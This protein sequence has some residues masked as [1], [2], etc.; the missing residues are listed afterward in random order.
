MKRGNLLHLL[1]IVVVTLGVT[2][3]IWGAALA[4]DVTPIRVGSTLALTG[5]LAATGKIHQIAGTE[6]VKLLNERGGLL[7]RPVE[8]VL[9]DD[10]GTGDKAAAGY[11][12][13]ITAERVDLL[14]GPYGTAATV[15]AQG[16]ADRYGY[17]LP[18]PAQS[19]TYNNVYDRQFMAWPTGLDTHI[20]TPGIIFDAYLNTPN[21][22]KTVAFVVS[23]F[24][25]AQFLVYG[26][27]G[28]GGAIRVAEEKG[29]QVV[30]DIS[31]DLGTTD[32]T[33]IA[34]RIRQADPDLLFVGALGEDGPNLMAAMA[35]LGYR[36][37]GQFYLWPS[38]GPMLEAGP[39][40]EG[41]TSI[42][43]FENN[44]AYLRNHG[45]PEFVERFVRAAKEAG[46][47]YT[48]PE[49]QAAS[50]WAAWQILVAG[51]EGCQ[52]LD[53]AG[54][55]E[56]IQNNTIPT[57]FGDLTFD[58]NQNNVP[59]DIQAVKQIQNGQWVVVYPDRWAVEGSQLIY[60]SR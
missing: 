58:R 59:P 32:F 35:Q 26:R 12:R 4:Q 56:Y 2:L 17:V 43:A 1:I 25:S 55:A 23:R 19:L 37:R 22:P 30:L 3:G 57:V 44:A 27:D 31:Y 7:G 51:V 45:A 40:A 60:P 29:L 52:C 5:G 36:P 41:A 46:L 15:A 21:P 11:E 50:Q 53:Q 38:P 34:L 18:F 28:V 33:A 10:E 8:W 13:L 16:V 42:T 54:I 9:L 39:L 20:S 24:P 6:F 48:D 49:I 47:P 14:V